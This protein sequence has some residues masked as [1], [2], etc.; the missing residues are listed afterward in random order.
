MLLII[1][2]NYGE[3]NFELRAHEYTSGR[4]IKFS[5][6]VL[7]SLPFFTHSLKFC[8]FFCQHSLKFCAKCLIRHIPGRNTMPE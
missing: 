8:A 2:G 3:G 7:S 4:K 6:R 5:H 1:P